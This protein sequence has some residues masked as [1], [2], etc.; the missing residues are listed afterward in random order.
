M[1]GLGRRSKEI[2]LPWQFNHKH[3]YLMQAAFQTHKLTNY[4]CSCATLS[5][6]RYLCMSQT[7]NGGHRT[8]RGAQEAKAKYHCRHAIIAKI[9][10]AFLK[11]ELG[12]CCTTGGDVAK[13]AK[14]VFLSIRLMLTELG[15][16]LSCSAQ[17]EAVISGQVFPAK[18]NS[19]VNCR[20]DLLPW[21]SH[22]DAWRKGVRA[23]F[24]A[25]PTIPGL[26][27]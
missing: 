12:S 22:V 16:I 10:I 15:Q 17:Y 27:C 18:T 26:P 9:L 5:W 13:G 4:A 6:L 20:M 11:E 23:A 2:V 7:A 19:S 3:E 21:Y 24:R 1:S 14:P 25:T 8:P